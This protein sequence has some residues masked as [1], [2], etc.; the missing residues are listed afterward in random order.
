[1]GNRNKNV[2]KPQKKF[3]MQYS[4]ISGTHEKYSDFLRNWKI[5]KYLQI[6][7]KRKSL[8][9]FRKNGKCDNNVNTTWG[10][11]NWQNPHKPNFINIVQVLSK[12]IR[13][14]THSFS[15]TLKGSITFYMNTI[16]GIF[17]NNINE[18]LLKISLFLKRIIK[19]IEH[20][21]IH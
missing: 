21:L 15:K 13:A 6:Y 3:K 9:Y 4:F 7:L 8:L 16:S 5:K 19:T 14:Y 17:K 11:A 10:S 18:M 2:R 12:I 1:M 20:Y